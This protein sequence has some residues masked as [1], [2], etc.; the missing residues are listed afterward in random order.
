MRTS[1]ILVAFRPTDEPLT[2]AC[3]A[4]LRAGTRPPDEIVLVDNGLP[5]EVGARLE[6]AL[7][8]DGASDAVVLRTGSNLGFTGG[9]NA[10]IAHALSG[11]ADWVWVL[12]N[13]TEVEPECLER[14]LE[15]AGAFP[16]AGCVGAH[17]LHFDDPRRIWFAGGD[18]LVR[19]ALGSHH[20]LGTLEDGMPGDPSSHGSARPREVTFL[21]GCSML[22]RA[23]ALHEV[24]PFREDLFAYVEDAELSLR[25]RRAGWSLL[26]APGARLYHK[27][28][29]PEGEPPPWKIEL[30]DRN[31][32]RLV[33]RHYGVW[34]R[35]RFTLWFYPTRAIHLVRYLARGDRARARAIVRG[36]MER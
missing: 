23:E 3:V 14:L 35:L 29:W 27:V 13:D 20:A 8:A 32:R 26:Y 25:L 15:V 6:A 28:P 36:V 34:D 19:K 12:N 21:T 4:S 9:N 22:L 2:L 30:R 16:E 24:G 18:F 10:G 1:V 11:G 31:R 33:R 5:R 7:T 17:I